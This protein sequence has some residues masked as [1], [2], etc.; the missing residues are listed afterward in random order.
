MR[1]IL[2]YGILILAISACNRNMSVTDKAV[3]SVSILPQKYFIEQIVGEY[4]EVNVLIPPGASPATYEPVPQQIADLEKSIAYFK[5]GYIGFENSWMNKILS[6]NKEMA[7]FD[8]SQGIELIREAE[9]SHGDH[10][11]Q[12]GIDP[13]IW[14]SPKRVKIIAENIYMAMVQID[15]DRE[16]IYHENY[17]QFMGILDTL[18]LKIEQMVTDFKGRSFIVFHPALTYLAADYGLEQIAIEWEGKEPSPGHLMELIDH[19]RKENIKVVLVQEQFDMDNAR[20]IAEELDGRIIRINPLDEDWETS[21]TR[22]V[23]SLVESFQ[24]DGQ[25]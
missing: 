12:G 21:V 7:L 6:V 13:H 2:Y 20:T 22:I 16:Q 9:L 4:F 10:H 25:R 1:Q 17:L 24:S 23:I 11:H 15:P 19:G 3:I 18:D 8:L 5:I 14:L